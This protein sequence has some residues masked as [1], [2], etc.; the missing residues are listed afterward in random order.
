MTID[1]EPLKIPAII[2]KLAATPG[3]TDWPGAPL[4]A[5]NDE[6]YRNLLGMSEAELATLR[7]DGVV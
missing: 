4:G 5:H 6:V 3:R 7:Q 2:P 1:G